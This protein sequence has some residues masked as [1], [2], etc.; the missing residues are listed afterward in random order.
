M[1]YGISVWPNVRFGSQSG[2][3]DLLDRG[4]LSGKSRHMAGRAVPDL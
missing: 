3:A 2:H 4:L 1:R